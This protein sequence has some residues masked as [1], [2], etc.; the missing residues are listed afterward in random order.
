MGKVLGAVG[1]QRKDNIVWFWG[2]YNL[3]ETEFFFLN[4]LLRN[5]YLKENVND[6]SS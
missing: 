3:M 4:W 1:D 6:P 5:Y 2:T